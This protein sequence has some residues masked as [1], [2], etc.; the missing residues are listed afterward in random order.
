MLTY[1][2]SVDFVDDHLAMGDSQ[3]IK[4]VKDFAVAIVQDTTRH[5]KFNKN[6]GIP[7]MVGSIDCSL[8]LEALSCSY[9]MDSS[10]ATQK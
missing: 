4:Y 9:G 10:M 7:G 5:L 8:E 2:I 6:H 1:Y 3:A